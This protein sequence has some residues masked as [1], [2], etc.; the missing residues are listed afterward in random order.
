MYAVSFLKKGRAIIMALPILFL[1]VSCSTTDTN[2]QKAIAVRALKAA[3]QAGAPLSA[4]ASKSYYEA[5]YQLK[6]GERWMLDKKVMDSSN[7]YFKNAT[8]LAEQ[9]EEEAIFCDK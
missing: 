5:A 8:T 3:E 1:Y 6:L 2:L 9:A 7:S 4:C